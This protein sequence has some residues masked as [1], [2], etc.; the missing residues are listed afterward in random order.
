MIEGMY[1]LNPHLVLAFQDWELEFVTN[2][3]DMYS[4]FTS[5]RGDDK[6]YWRLPKSSKFEVRLFCNGFRG[7]E[8]FDLKKLVIQ[9]LFTWRVTLHFKSDCSFSDFLDLCSPFSLD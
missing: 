6:M 2:F 7:H 1:Y 4:N 9:T 8:G 3:F 5:S